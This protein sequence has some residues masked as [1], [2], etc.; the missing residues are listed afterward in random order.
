MKNK[1]L[2][3]LVILLLFA[4]S[5]SSIGQTKI[6]NN[7][8][9]A[10][11]QL[12]YDLYYKYGIL[13]MKG[14]NATLNT[15]STVYNG[16][17]AYKMTLHA[18]TGGLINSIYNV[19]DTLTGFVDK[20]IVPLLFTKGATEG[21][22]YTRERQIYKYQ[23]GETFI[24]TIRHRNGKLSFDEN[25]TTERCTYDMMSVL[26]F[27]RTL[28]Y[29]NMKRGD[30]THVQF[31]SGRRL[32]NMYIRYLGTISMKVNNGK[33]YDA[34]ELSLMILDKAFVDQEEAMNVW[35]TN[36]ENKLPLQINTKLKIGTMRAVLKDFSGNKHPLN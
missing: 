1:K 15:E 21:K 28:D 7:A 19:D 14:G 13:N 16:T 6:K 24:R 10:G 27:A 8:F 36:D 26:A 30:N 34:L 25:I 35:I 20:N 11:E 33:T 4:V 23:N 2:H 18:T 31:I 22:D 12:T 32:V 3:S 17:D 9:D 5:L 29:S